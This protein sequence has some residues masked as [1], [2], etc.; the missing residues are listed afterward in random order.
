MFLS[1]NKRRSQWGVNTA[2]QG[3]GGREPPRTF[4]KYVFKHLKTP[5][6]VG[7]SD[8]YPVEEWAKKKFEQVTDVNAIS[9][10]VLEAINKSPAKTTEPEEQLYLKGIK[11]ESK[12]YVPLPGLFSGVGIPRVN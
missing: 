4:S 9:H 2:P 6:G 11:R 12:V 8:S 7:V 3:S 10:S 1:I 5:G